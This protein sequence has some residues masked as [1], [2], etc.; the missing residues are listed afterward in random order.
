VDA[1]DDGDSDEEDEGEEADNGGGGSGFARGPAAFDAFVEDLEEPSTSEPGSSATTRQLWPSANGKWLA[2][3]A[4]STGRGS[5]GGS[6][7][8][9]SFALVDRG[10]DPEAS[11]RTLPP[12]PLAAEAE[13][14]SDSGRN[15]AG[16]GGGLRAFKPWRMMRPADNGQAVYAVSGAGEPWL[17]AAA[18]DGNGSG[19][20]EGGGEVAWISLP[21]PPT[22]P[23][24]TPTTSAVDT[25]A[26][27]PVG[28]G[29]VT[30]KMRPSSSLSRPIDPGAA[31]FVTGGDS[32]W[33]LARA[34]VEVSL[35]AA[36]SIRAS[37]EATGNVAV[38]LGFSLHVAAIV[39]PVFDVF[40][41]VGRFA[42]AAAVSNGEGVGPGARVTAAW[43]ETV[44]D[45]IFAD[46]GSCGDS[47]RG[48]SVNGDRSASGGG[49]GIAG[50]RLTRRKMEKRTPLGSSV[51]RVS[52]SSQASGS[53]PR[54]IPTPATPASP[55]ARRSSDSD[56]AHSPISSSSGGPRTSEDDY[57]A[58]QSRLLR[59]P[60]RVVAIAWSPDGSSL[61]VAVTGGPPVNTA[62]SP[63]DGQPGLK[64]QSA[65]LV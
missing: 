21:S 14:D 41:Q 32:G 50:W 3:A 42:S 65:R 38:P 23:P 10:A 37:S 46:G 54:S 13:A 1:I 61:A 25:A 57:E 26:A 55:G 24:P 36:P 44:L 4:T 45:Y 59:M 48:G 49:A 35:I 20:E 2:V 56:G 12:P 63:A 28:G 40:P 51:A 17:W 33:A 6:G 11:P 34:R 64:D 16:G 29:A 8:D 30:M 62:G 52:F 31:R 60:C 5:G 58:L 27:T 19:S 18:S 53:A 47:G 43:K 22:P 39:Q 9:V 15:T 7:G